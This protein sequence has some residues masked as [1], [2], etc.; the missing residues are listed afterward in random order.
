MARAAELL[1]LP[2]YA[3][4]KEL[5]VVARQ[6]RHAGPLRARRRADPGL[7]QGS[8]AATG[9][10]RCADLFGYPAG[11]EAEHRL[12]AARRFGRG[13]A[14]PSSVPACA[15]HLEADR[16]LLRD[17]TCLVEKFVGDREF[18]VNAYS[19]GTEYFEVLAVT[20]RIITGYPEPPGITFAEV[21][22]PAARARTNRTP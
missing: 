2:F 14:R 4:P 22:P 17:P 13:Q 21:Y 15:R 3:G 18:S 8:H 20:E 10:P 11:R 7:R 19:L 1:A 5:R 16:A 12:G 9:V 6:G